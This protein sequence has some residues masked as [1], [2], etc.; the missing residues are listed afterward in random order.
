MIWS[1]KRASHFIP[2][3]YV[4]WK[5]FPN[6]KA[7][8]FVSRRGRGDGGENISFFSYHVSF[9]RR[10]ALAAPATAYIDLK[11]VTSP[12]NASKFRY[13]EL[14]NFDFCLFLVTNLASTRMAFK[15]FTTLREACG[16]VSRGGGERKIYGNILEIFRFRVIFHA[17]FSPRLFCFTLTLT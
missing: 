12:W 13:S 15:I 5:F 2:F 8:Q 4:W 1:W 11:F 6:T 9:W 16:V 7:N 3:T 14:F 10:T 17:R